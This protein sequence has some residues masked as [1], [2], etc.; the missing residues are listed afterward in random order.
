MF[1]KPYHVIG[2]IA[3]AEFNFIVQ[4]PSGIIVL[5]RPTS[6]FANL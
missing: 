4:E 3:T 6:L 1:E 5:V 2:I